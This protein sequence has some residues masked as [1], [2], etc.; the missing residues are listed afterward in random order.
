MRKNLGRTI[1]IALISIVSV[2]IIGALVAWNSPIFGTRLP[3]LNSI[4]NPDALE[5]QAS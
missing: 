5:N 4:F 1:L 3:K 2:L